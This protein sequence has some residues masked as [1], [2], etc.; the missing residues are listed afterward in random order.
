MMGKLMDQ[1]MGD[2]RPKRHIPPFS[3]F[4]QKRA[5]EKPNAVGQG[6]GVR[7]KPLGARRAFVKT[8]E[9]KRV[10]NPHLRAK[11][12][13]REIGK[14]KLHLCRQGGKRRGQG[15]PGRLGHL[16]EFGQ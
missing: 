7:Q 10:F 3:P 12:I 15:G 6:R 1:N 13:A 4:I 2:K 9:F 11:L 16:R 8:A 14:A 5:A